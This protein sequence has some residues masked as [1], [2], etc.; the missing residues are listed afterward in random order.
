MKITDRN[1]YDNYQVENLM[2]ENFRIRKEAIDYL[3]RE[4]EYTKRY[5]IAR[6]NHDEK[7]HFKSD[8]ARLKLLAD[9]INR[10]EIQLID[11]FGNVDDKGDGNGRYWPAP[12]YSFVLC[13][14]DHTM[15]Q[16]N[17]I[18][19][20][21]MVSLTQR[22][23]RNASSSHPFH[24]QPPVRRMRLSEAHIVYPDT[25]YAIESI[26][27]DFFNRIK[28][29][30]LTSHIFKNMTRPIM[31][32]A[33]GR[34]YCLEECFPQDSIPIFVYSR[35]FGELVEKEIDIKYLLFLASPFKITVEPQLLGRYCSYLYGLS[36]VLTPRYFPVMIRYSCLLAHE[37]FHPIVTITE[38][39][40]TA[41][42]SYAKAKGDERREKYEQLEKEYGFAIADLFYDRIKAK[43]SIKN[44]LKLSLFGKYDK[45]NNWIASRGIYFKNAS[46]VLPKG[47]KNLP[48]EVLDE[49]ATAYTRELISDLAALILCPSFL[50]AL[51]CSENLEGIW[52]IKL[53]N[54]D[55][56]HYEGDYGRNLPTHPP[57]IIRIKILI[58]ICRQIGLSETAQFTEDL[59]N[60]MIEGEPMGERVFN[61]IWDIWEKDWWNK[62][63]KMINNLLIHL[64]SAIDG[65]PLYQDSLI[66][67][68]INEPPIIAEKQIAEILQ[69]IIDRAEKSDVYL[70]DI[71]STIIN[72]ARE[73]KEKNKENKIGVRS[74]FK[75]RPSDILAAIWRKLLDERYK[76]YEPKRLQ[77]R[78]MLEKNQWNM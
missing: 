71:N 25:I 1:V 58:K 59:V 68:D 29:S 9:G 70:D 16:L 56:L 31:A 32:V 53:L 21:I 5:C 67:K 45:K 33:R 17:K 44:F 63:D 49:M 40:H 30:Y 77:W 57:I 55:Y 38:I 34:R 24:L 69:I 18:L 65:T 35:S 41:D 62:A 47:Y 6:Q 46:T 50:P 19:H 64:R 76:D 42:N 74:S 51:A 4:I 66:Q 15:Q 73:N 27:D 26:A 7:G 37:L 11:L 10:L 23:F 22:R 36:S 8:R 3:K 78:L 60:K 13:W 2:V 20:D 61:K 12:S 28:A 52:N 72:L 14:I 75:L 43:N 48:E 39:I 54:N